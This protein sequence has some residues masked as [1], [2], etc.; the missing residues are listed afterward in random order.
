ML[1]TLMYLTGENTRQKSNVHAQEHV[2]IVIYAHVNRKIL[3]GHTCLM[4][5]A[6][7]NLIKNPTFHSYR[8]YNLKQLRHK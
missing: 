7:L 3:N 1:E 8:H 6:T 4:E 5:M 2:Q